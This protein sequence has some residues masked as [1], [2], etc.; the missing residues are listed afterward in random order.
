MM[1]FAN[2]LRF[3]KSVAE[4]ESRRPPKEP[5]FAGSF[6]EEFSSDTA[7]HLNINEIHGWF[8]RLRR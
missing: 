7:L 5:K 6:Q 3:A 4:S 8:M 1:P 2:F